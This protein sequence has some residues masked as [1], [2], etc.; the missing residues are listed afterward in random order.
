MISIIIPVYNQAKKIKAT[1]ES[2]ANQTLA[3]WEVIVVNDGST[4]NLEAEF[5]AFL[6][7]FSGANPFI[8]LNQENKGAPAA[9]NTGLSKARGEFLLFCDSDAILDPRAL[10]LWQAALLFDSQAAFAY[11]AFKWGRRL[12][13]VGSYDYDRL[14]REPYIHT[15]SLIRRSAFPASGWDE[16]LKR[17]Q[18]WDLWLTIAAAGGYGVFVDQVLFAVSPGGHISAWLPAFSYRF[19]KF[20]PA[21]K[22]YHAAKEIIYNKHQIV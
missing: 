19:L 16:D 2:I 10:E 3:D 21:V 18:D 5:T 13:K 14:R 4:D 20:L 9:R 12:F 8:F 11:S 6:D 22:K 1:L 17:F 15:T 7:K